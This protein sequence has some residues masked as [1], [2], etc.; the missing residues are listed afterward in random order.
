MES[1]LQ[2]CLR[3]ILINKSFF[4]YKVASVASFHR[5]ETQGLELLLSR[6]VLSAQLQPGKDAAIAIGKIV[7]LFAALDEVGFPVL[8]NVLWLYFVDNLLP[9]Y[10]FIKNNL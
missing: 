8:E 2:A 9:G 6:Q 7:E 5:A 4:F 10:E 3:Q 1:D